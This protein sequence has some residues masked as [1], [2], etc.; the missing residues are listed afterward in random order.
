MKMADQVQAPD[1]AAVI[2]ALQERFAGA[3]KADDRKGYEGIIVNTDKLLD[4]ATAIR[5]E[6]GYNYLSSATAVD[7]LGVDDHIEM[8]YHAFR[9]PDGGPAL[10]FKAQTR[11]DNASIPSLIRIWPGADFQEREAW[12]LYGIH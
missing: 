1:K 9:V 11:R 12:D 10:V 7:Y 2:A 4:V 3:V 8:V 6:Y 5:D